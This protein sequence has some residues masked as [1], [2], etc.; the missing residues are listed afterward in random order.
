[1]LT[2]S[3]SLWAKK[4][5]AYD[6]L[7]AMSVKGRF[8]DYQ[9]LRKHRGVLQQHVKNL[10][11]AKVP[12]SKA[13]RMAFY[14]NA[15]NALVLE[16]VLAHDLDKSKQQVLSVKGFFDQKMYPVAGKNLTLNQLEG[17]YIRNEGDARIHF[18][19]NCASYDCP[20][21]A[22]KPYTA[23]QLDKQ[24]DAVTKAYLGRKGEVVVD[25]AKK[26]ITVVQLFEWYVGDFG[27]EPGV[28]TFL[29]A[30]APANKAYL[31]KSYRIQH[32]PYDWRLNAV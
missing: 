8:V 1:M 21:L 5:L 9:P 10:A 12:T 27:A 28:R 18:A 4:S 19:V 7:L 15:Y 23:P 13:G 11:T 16:A 24:L 6:G 32:R 31:D 2:T 25:D 14:I 26:T 17:E 30:H 3:S 20:P 29:Q 22:N